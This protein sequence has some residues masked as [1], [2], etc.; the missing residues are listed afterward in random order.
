MLDNRGGADET[1]ASRLVAINLETRLPSTVF[2]RSSAQE[3]ANPFY[4]MIAGHLDV[5]SPDRALV[6]LTMRGEIWEV[7]LATGDVLWEYVYVDPDTRER[8]ALYTAK[9]VGDVHFEFNR[10]KEPTP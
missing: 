2:P 3:F 4:T 1:G 6:T 7:D 8:R 5:R 9:Y 10:K